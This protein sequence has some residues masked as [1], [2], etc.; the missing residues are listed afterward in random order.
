MIIEREIAKKVISMSNSFKVVMLC[1]PR[2]IGK[3]TILKGLCDSERTYVSLDNLE[4]RKL[5]KDSPDLFFQKYKPPILIDEV[6]YAPELLSYIK[7]IVDQSNQKGIFWLTG[8]Q[9]FHLMKNVTE[10]LA[11]RV[12]ILYMNSLT[13]DEKIEQ[14]LHGPFDPEKIRCYKK[15]ELMDVFEDIF[16]GSMPGCCL[17]KDMNRN[18]FYDS[19]I[20]TYIDRDVKDLT[21]VGNELSF[22]QFI[23]S[24]AARTGEQLNY[25]ALANDANITVPTAKTWLSILITSGLVYLLQPYSNN[26]LTRTVKMPKIVFMDTGL[27]TFLTKWDS[28][29][30]LEAS[31]VSGH[32]F[33]TW[34][35]SEIVKKYQNNGITNPPIFYYRDK[36]K[37]EIDLIIDKNNKLYPF[38]IKKTA[39]P[40][41]EIVKTFNMLNKTKKEIGTGGIICMYQEILPIDEKNYIIPVGCI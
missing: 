33:E 34:I 25:T 38:E 30:T 8:S 9:Q 13:Y 31:S 2:Q 32:V 39:N 41:K 36:D 21:Q 12:G 18:D 27:C 17:D 37:N 16:E 3:T 10:S 14:I 19:Y 4:V 26:I 6:Q 24:V 20:R 28:K 29:E 7:I 35:I 40:N 23:T 11:G 22:Y 5:A 15:L 1:G